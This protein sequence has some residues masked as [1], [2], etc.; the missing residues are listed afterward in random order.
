MYDWGNS[1]QVP[2]YGV[3]D[4]VTSVV[5]GEGVTTVGANAPLRHALSGERHASLH[6]RLDR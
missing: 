2:W 5:I 1:D 4:Q 6:A 3:R